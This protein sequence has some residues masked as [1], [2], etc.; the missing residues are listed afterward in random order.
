MLSV[1]NRRLPY[2]YK[3]DPDNEKS[4]IKIQRSGNQVS[5][6]HLQIKINKSG[7]TDG[8]KELK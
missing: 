6:E 4:N 8:C 5:K 7:E 2:K 3:R 1:T